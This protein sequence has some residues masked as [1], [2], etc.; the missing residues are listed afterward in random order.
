MKENLI[1]KESNTGE[2]AKVSILEENFVSREENDKYSSDPEENDS[3][4]NEDNESTKDEENDST[5][6]EEKDSIREEENDSIKDE[7]NIL[8]G[9]KDDLSEVKIVL[10]VETKDLVI[11]EGKQEHY[12]TKKIL[13]QEKQINHFKSMKEKDDKERVDLNIKISELEKQLN[14]EKAM[15]GGFYCVNPVCT[16][17]LSNFNGLT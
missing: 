7:E 4:R 10:F 3:A 16:F 17:L 1:I 8:R 5:I 13:E 6:N 11:R 15:K 14:D 12:L 9:V 2:E